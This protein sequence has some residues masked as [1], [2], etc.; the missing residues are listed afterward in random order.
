MIKKA[1]EHP[2]F[3]LVRDGDRL[4][5]EMEMDREMI[6]E[7]PAGQRIQVDLR[8]GRVPSRLRFYFKFLREVVKATECAP[9]PKALHQIVKIKTGYTDKVKIG[10]LIV[11]VP[12]SIA[13]ESMDEPTFE[14]FLNN[15]IRFIASEFGVTPE[16][17]MPKREEH[18]RSA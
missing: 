15:A 5:G 14:G 17:V 16:E 2:P 6:R 9:H 10:D 1:P 18:R 7:F 12:S 4:I 8:T 13:F 11:E 3:Y